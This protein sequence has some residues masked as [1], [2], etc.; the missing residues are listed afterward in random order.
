M[1][2]ALELQVEA[3]VGRVH[4]V[5]DERIGE[6]RAANAD[7]LATLASGAR[8]EA[9]RLLRA[10]AHDKR[11]R[12]RERAREA[13]AEVEAQRRRS[14]FG[15]ER[16]LIDEALAALPAALE[17]RWRDAALRRAWWL[18]AVRVAAARLV[19]RDWQVAIA[20]PLDEPERAALAA[21]AAT[22]GAR[23]AFTASAARAGLAISAGASVVDA[24]PAGLLA[25]RSAIAARL[26]ALLLPG[27]AP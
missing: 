20:G 19:A 13:L 3:L 8:A 4:R 12:V 11:E 15:V 21:A 9:R 17:R 5:R 1:S 7:Q 18:G 23:V 22:C 27:A 10:A 16:R 14:G 2:G 25:D 26:L 24:T 6:L